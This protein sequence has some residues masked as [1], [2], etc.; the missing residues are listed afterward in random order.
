MCLSYV[1]DCGRLWSRIIFLLFFFLS[2]TMQIFQ[3]TIYA[4][5]H[6]SVRNSAKMELLQFYNTPLDKTR[7]D[8]LR[9]DPHA[10]FRHE[11]QMSTSSGKKLFCDFALTLHAISATE[12]ACER[13]FSR[14]GWVVGDH[15]TSLND[16]RVVAI[17]LLAAGGQTKI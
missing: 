5:K 9:E 1:Y 7:A 14:I 17:S 15:R 11:A 13:Q 16:D 3:D 2:K 10:F 4:S 12:M 6:Q 8:L